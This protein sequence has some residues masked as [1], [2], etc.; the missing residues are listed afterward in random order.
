MVV[1]N[2]ADTVVALRN[3]Y[4]QFGKYVGNDDRMSFDNDLPYLLFGDFALFLRA[5]LELAQ[6]GRINKDS[7]EIINAFEL[8]ES[9]IESDRPDILEL[10]EVAILEVINDNPLT[11]D[12]AKD[13][14]SGTA[15]EKYRSLASNIN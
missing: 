15:F 6:Q 1:N 2:V 4:P 13:S 5:R 9:L 10:V 12:I 8:L 7:K 14:F 11:C 3:L